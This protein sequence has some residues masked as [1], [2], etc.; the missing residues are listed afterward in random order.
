MMEPLFVCVAN[1]AIVGIFAKVA[2]HFDK[3]WIVL[4]ALLAIASY[5]ADKP[6]KKNPEESNQ[7]DGGTE[8]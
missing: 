3:W 1:I 5:R 8:E 4:F 6:T 7:T 2:M